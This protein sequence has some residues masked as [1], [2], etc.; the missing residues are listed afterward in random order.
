M[1]AKKTHDEYKAEFEEKFDGILELRD[2]I[3]TS[4]RENIRVYCLK[5]GAF[6]KVAS[7]LLKDN[8]SKHPCPKCVKEILAEEVIAAWPDYLE[9]IKNAVDCSD[10]DFSQVEYKGSQEKIEI[11]CK[12]HGSFKAIPASMLNKKSGCPKCG[13]SNRTKLGASKILDRLREVHGE[14]YNFEI[15][16]DAVRQTKIK[17]VCSKHGS[18]FAKIDA[19]LQGKGCRDCAVEARAAN[20]TLTTAE[21]IKRARKVHGERYSYDKSKYVTGKTKLIVTCKEHGDFEIN[22]SNHVSLKRGCKVCS[23]GS[24]LNADNS[25]KR[26]TQKQ[27]LFKANEVAPENLDFTKSVYKDTRTNVT[28]TCKIHGDFLIRPGN[29]FQGGNC[30]HCSADLAGKKHR[31]SKKQLVQRLKDKFG[32]LYEIDADSLTQATSKARLKCASH[33]WFE[34]VIGNLINSSGCPRCKNIKAAAIRSK[35]NKLT[36]SEIIKRFKNLK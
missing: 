18:K 15:P 31:V 1:P 14:T 32:D 10:L 12:K 17:Y 29:L 23:G 2:S 36:R 11:I 26:L 19:L 20:R 5:H 27:F 28:V 30:R 16:E 35:Q 25:K 8:R 9:K 13:Q 24:F 33:G 7:A 3:Y 22:P 21:W 34:G 4:A 6:E